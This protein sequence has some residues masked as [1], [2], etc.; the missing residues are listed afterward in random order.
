MIVG[1]YAADDQQYESFS[2]IVSGKQYKSWWIGRQIN[3]NISTKM[4]GKYSG[5]L[6]VGEKYFHIH[7]RV[8]WKRSSHSKGVLREISLLSSSRSLSLI[9]P[10]PSKPV[11]NLGQL[12]RNSY[13]ASPQ[14]EAK[15][16]KGFPYS[17]NQF[18]NPAELSWL[19][20]LQLKHS[21]WGSFTVPVGFPPWKRVTGP[22]SDRNHPW[23]RVIHESRATAIHWW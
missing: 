10:L 12:S 14:V 5:R 22:T 4:V 8:N 3:E 20:L 21:R 15:K 16:K 18:W 6:A 17:H 11:I 23:M 2:K 13:Q 9:P 19:I 1:V 7:W